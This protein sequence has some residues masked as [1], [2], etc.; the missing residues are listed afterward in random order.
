MV[1][2]DA[3]DI[4]LGQQAVLEQALSTNKATQKALQKLIRAAILEA[5]AEV[6]KKH[7]LRQWRPARCGAI[8]QDEC[9]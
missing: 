1:G 5:R 7:P 8:R 9:L 6:V 2:I 3:N 4:V